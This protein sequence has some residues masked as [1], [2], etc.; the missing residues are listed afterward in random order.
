MVLS[1]RTTSYTAAIF[2]ALILGF[3]LLLG[4]R[5]YKS[6]KEY[7][8]IIEQN[9]KIIFQFATIREHITESLLE[10]RYQQL[11]NITSEIENLNVSMSQV[12]QQPIIPDEYRISFAGQVD[13]AGITLLLRSIGSGDQTQAKIRQLNQEIRILGERLMLF[14]RV[15]VDHVK[16][17]LVG[18]QNFVIGLLAIILFIVIYILLFWHGQIA[19]PLIDLVK[20]AKEISSG[21]RSTIS[22]RKKSGEVAELAGS[23]QNLLTKQNRT[24][25]EFARYNR[26]L[27]MVHNVGESVWQVQTRDAVF[28]ETCRGILTNSDYILVWIGIPKDNS[29]IVPVIADGSTTMSRQEQDECMT[30]LLT[31]AEENPEKYDGAHKALEQKSPVI[32]RNILKGLPQGPF[33]NTPFASNTADCIALPLVYD[34]QIFGV[35][36]IYSIAALSFSEEEIELLKG[37]S[38]EIVFALFALAA[39]E[40][41]K[42]LA[43]LQAARKKVFEN[44]PD[45]ILVIRADGTIVEA[46]PSAEDKLGKGAGTVIG[47][48]IS[49]LFNSSSS[50]RQ[51]VDALSGGSENISMELTISGKEYMTSISLLKN[52]FEE[53]DT[54]LLIARDISDQKAHKIE[55]IK[56]SKLAAMGELSVGVANEINNLTNGLINYTQ[57]LSEE[58]EE[59]AGKNNQSIEL[60]NNVI[61]EGERISQIV[62]QLLFFNANRSQ[63]KEAVKINKIIEDSLALT[64]HQF[65]YDAIDVAIHFP[66]IV[67]SVKVNVQEMQHIFLNLLS[68]AR[69][70][71]NQRYPGPHSKKRIEIKGEITARAGQQYLKVTCTDFGVGIH[72]NIITKVFEPFFSTKPEGIGTGLGLSICRSIAEDNN[73]ILEIESI[74]DDHTSIIMELPV[75][76]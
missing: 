1:L 67:P 52:Q 50:P 12:L 20:Q 71:L 53:N 6:H 64:K 22:V 62:Q 18:F 72:P 47:T 25:S 27:E 5:Q 26:V 59:T 74:L 60:L 30:A 29:H 70:A 15:I 66:D 8:N 9:E 51:L 14:D 76:A 63:S 43:R 4:S 48:G 35:M 42:T 17:K 40:S 34:Q 21:K 65:K 56:A 24:S 16:R 68:N 31:A 28:G 10:N 73:G 45:L 33:K 55:T 44:N 36:N 57:I 13:F 69:Y 23:F 49:D 38:R 32:L 39:K 11:N 75:A 37:M 7:E 61:K 41:N 54:Y 46:N 2:I 3:L 19:M 58:I